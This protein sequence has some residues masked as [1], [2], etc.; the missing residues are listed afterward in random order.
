MSD[1]VTGQPEGPPPPDF[2]AL[3]ESAPG[4]YLVLNTDLKIVAVSN[5]YLWATM[6][7]REAILG[8]GIFEIFPDNPDD[9]HATGM[10]NLNASLER[11]LR[12]RATDGMPVQSAAAKGSCAPLSPRPQS[13]NCSSGNPRS[14]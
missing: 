6:T 11:V 3:F 7:Q 14:R 5:A 10:R 13:L 4:L 9:R 8:R 2:R 12:N 1:Q